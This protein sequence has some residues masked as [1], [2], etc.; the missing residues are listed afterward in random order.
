MHKYA[1]LAPEPHPPTTMPPRSAT[2]QGSPSASTGSFVP[3][4][5]YQY[6]QQ[7]AGDRHQTNPPADPLAQL[8][9]KYMQDHQQL[10]QIILASQSTTPTPSHTENPRANIDLP[11]WEE[12]MVFRV[13]RSRVYAFIANALLLMSGKNATDPNFAHYSRQL[14]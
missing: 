8:I 10:M 13:Y 12:T 3:P 11:K 9:L 1:T 7:Q 14:H 6:S 2:I 4:L 5:Q